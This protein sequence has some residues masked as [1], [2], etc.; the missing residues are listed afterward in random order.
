MKFIVLVLFSVS[1]TSAQ[2]SGTITQ[3][4]T[5]NVVGTAGTL[6]CTLTNTTP[7]LVTRVHVAC[8]NSGAS[9]LVMDS[10]VP[11]GSNGM[12]GSMTLTGNTVTW[13][14]NQPTV[15]GLYS[16]QMAAN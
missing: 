5:S 14:I 12:V 3:S 7:V 10:V 6:V 13:L 1:F 2:T 11:V 16:W 8:V 15:G 9:V 4:S